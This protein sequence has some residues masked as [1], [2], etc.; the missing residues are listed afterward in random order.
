MNNSK[1]YSHTE[2]QIE[3]EPNGYNLGGGAAR[4]LRP[5][6]PV[7]LTADNALNGQAGQ[8]FITVDYANPAVNGTFRLIRP[9]IVVEGFDPGLLISPENQFG[10]LNLVGFLDQL[11]GSPDLQTLLQS[12]VQQ[13]DIIYVDWARGTDFLQRNA[14]LLERV[15]RW[16]N[17]QKALD[18]SVEP[19]VILGQSMGGVISRWALRDMENRGLNHQTR[20][21]IS[22]DGAQQGANVPVAYQHLARHANSLFVQSAIPVL[23]GGLNI[24]TLA[25]NALNLMDVP[26]ARQMLMNRAMANGEINN[27]DHDNWQLELRNLGY[28]SQTRNVAVSNGSECGI[29]QGFLPNADLINVNGRANTRF[30]SEL[31]LHTGNFG[32]WENLSLLTN[33]PQFLL[34]IVPGG[35]DFFFELNCK[36]QPVNS[37]SQIYK[38]KITYRKK[39]LWLISI[40][41]TITD[42]T[43]NSNPSLLAIDGT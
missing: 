12:D 19:N 39:I 27:V 33:K 32:F 24:V 17:E 9:L 21:F 8:R 16:V 40:N 36:A 15:I 37:T 11:R 41:T 31:A 7:F 6:G 14:L 29:G 25:G 13:Y 38:G 5:D 42:R 18:G 4:F 26:A 43:R 35:N 1:L 30:L 10:V 22:W 2:M 23:L 34:G 3:P 28:P 20:L